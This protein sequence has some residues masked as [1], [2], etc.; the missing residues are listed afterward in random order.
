MT[1]VEI[2]AIDERT[3]N[4]GT[5]KVLRFMWGKEQRFTYLSKKSQDYWLGKNKNVDLIKVGQ[6][7]NV[8]EN[9]DQNS[10]KLNYKII[11]FS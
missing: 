1:K 6:I 5:I 10:G 9:Y 3:N 2:M 7:I 4:L 8:I 11:G